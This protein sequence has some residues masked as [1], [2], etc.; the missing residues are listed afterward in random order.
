[1]S[2]PVSAIKEV[3][4]NCL[5]AGATKINVY[6]N[7]LAKFSIIDNGKKRQTRG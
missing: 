3:V 5:D 4:E 6:A 2:R 7:D 1:V